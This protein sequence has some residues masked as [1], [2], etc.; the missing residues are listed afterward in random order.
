MC[1]ITAVFH[2]HGGPVDESVLAQMTDS[3]RHRGP[4]DAGLWRD[5]PVGLGHRRLSIIDLSPA[6]HQPM[7][8][9]DGSLWIVFNGEVYNFQEVRPVLERDGYRFRSR[10]DTEVILHAYD[11]WGPACL[12]RFNGMFAFAIWDAR[13]RELFIARDRFGVK[14]LYYWFDGRRFCLASEIKALLNYPGVP[15]RPDRSIAYDYLALGLMDHR[16]DTFFEDIRR[17][18][19]ATWM[20]VSESG[21]TTERYFRPGSAPRRR[22]EDEREVIEEFRRLFADAVRLRLISDVRVGTNLSGGLDSSC[23]ACMVVENLSRAPDAG[24]GLPHITFSACFDDPAVDERPYIDLVAR[25]RPLER[26]YTFPKDADLLEQMHAH[27]LVQDQPV[28]SAAMLAKGQVMKLARE[29]GIKVVLEGQGADEYLAGYTEAAAPAIADQVLAARW[30]DAARQFRAYRRLQGIRPLRAAREVARHLMPPEAA[31]WLRNGSVHR[32]PWVAED[33]V[34][35]APNP[36]RRFADGALDNW[37]LEGLGDHFLPFY[38]RSDDHNAMAYSVEGRQPFL[39]YRLV[40]FVLSLPNEFR[41]RRGMSKWI[42]REAMR[43][44]VPEE[45]CRSPGK[46][47]FPTS[48]AQWLAGSQRTAIESLFS[49]RAF[50]SRGFFNSSGARDTL[51]RFCDGAG[52]LR[53][54]VWRLANYELWLQ[55]FRM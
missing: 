6:G 4:D 20:R 23:V 12:E 51:A 17:V 2:L 7:S 16:D 46:R 31:S 53:T 38:L 32:M 54:A 43:G 9:A 24:G 8:N 18:P 19:A 49:S 14:P 48:E 40:E 26:K 34:P 15:R 52:Y 29:H 5:G 50:A 25:D 41:I 21:I 11:R 30:L 45:I 39:D 55:C 36:P 22:V 10:T 13:R 3:I 27:M 47:A 44:L 35:A 1:G 28:M 42:L 33:L 37:C